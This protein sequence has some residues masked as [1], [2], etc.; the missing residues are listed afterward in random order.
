MEQFRDDLGDSRKFQQTE[1]TDAL[2][3]S[4]LGSLA[5]IILVILVVIAYS[6]FTFFYLYM[7]GEFLVVILVLLYI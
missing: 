6:I 4:L 5:G 2:R 1:V 7:Y 3:R